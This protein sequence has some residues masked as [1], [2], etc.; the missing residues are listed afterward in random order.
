MLIPPKYQVTPE[1]IEL[2]GKIESIRQHLETVKIP[3][4]TKQKIQRI[5]LLKSSLYSAK[6]EGNPL[7]FENYSTSPDKKN[8]QEIENIY[9]SLLYINKLNTKL[10]SEKIIKIIHQIVMKDIHYQAGKFRKE[11]SAIFNQAGIAV[12]VCPPPNKINQLIGN[13]SDYV[14]LK[15]KEFPLI[16]A[17]LAHIIFEKIHPFLDGNGRVGRLLIPLVC[18]L[19]KYEFNIFVSFE[20]FLNENKDDYYYHL[21]IGL[22]NPNAYLL[23]MLNAFYNQTKRLKNQIEIEIS[24]KNFFNLSIRQE[25]IFNIIKDHKHISLDFIKRRFLK[26]PSRTLRYDLKKLCDKKLITKVGI[27]KGSYYKLS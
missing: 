20:E 25:E 8:K 2:L 13:L 10:F 9:D 11:M 24:N 17:F 16:K 18:K 3:L 22:K 1:I 6:I 14:N 15:D 5:S 12:Y 19:K 21:D 7:I 4:E 23:F 27:T 26:V